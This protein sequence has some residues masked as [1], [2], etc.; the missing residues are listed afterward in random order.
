MPARRTLL[1]KVLDQVAR[2]RQID[3]VVPLP[4]SNGRIV[5]PAPPVD[6]P[7][8]R[9]LGQFKDTEKHA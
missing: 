4:S 8:R 6:T 7:L 5:A 2:R 3:F 9:T 1:R